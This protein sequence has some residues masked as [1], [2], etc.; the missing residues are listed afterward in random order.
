MRS[1]PLTADERSM[2][3][4]VAA[5]LGGN[6]GE[7]SL[8]DM[9]RATA[10]PMVEDGSLIR[11]EIEGYSRP[12][13]EGQHDSGSAPPRF[14]LLSGMVRS[15]RL[16]EAGNAGADARVHR[17]GSEPCGRRCVI[18]AMSSKPFR[19]ITDVAIV[20]R[21]R[22]IGLRRGPPVADAQHFLKCE[23]CGVS[24]DCRDLGDVFSH[25][26]PLPHDLVH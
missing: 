18:T 21:G 6:R 3:S 22:H 2:I 23:A 9:R 5:T 13:Y 7:Q 8:L 26:G 1:R 24:F 16:H 11:F 20:P 14:D 12:T 10:Q 19:Q 15:C 25:E 4:Q 17:P